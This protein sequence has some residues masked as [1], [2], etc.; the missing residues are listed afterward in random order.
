[1]RCLQ[2]VFAAIKWDAEQALRYA[3]RIV[4]EHRPVP[5]DVGAG[6]LTH[7]RVP[8]DIGERILHGSRVGYFWKPT[9]TQPCSPLPSTE[10]TECQEHQASE[11][12]ARCQKDADNGSVIPKKPRYDTEQRAYHDGKVRITYESPLEE[13]VTS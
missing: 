13:P 10:A 6:S 5:T 1:M 11:G 7:C 12:E 4:W 9:A 8:R 3:G 2:A